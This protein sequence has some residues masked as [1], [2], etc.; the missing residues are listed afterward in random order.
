MSGLLLMGQSTVLGGQQF[1][2]R[3]VM[4]YAFPS[5]LNLLANIE[6]PPRKARR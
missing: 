1:D 5:P 3:T 4:S 2:K 6:S